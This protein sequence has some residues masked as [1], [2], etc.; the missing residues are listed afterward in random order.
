MSKQ[1]NSAAERS[2]IIEY[3]RLKSIYSEFREKFEDHEDHTRTKNG[4]Y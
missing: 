1:Q 4:K 3:D 2:K